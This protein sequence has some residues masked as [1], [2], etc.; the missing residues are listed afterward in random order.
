MLPLIYKKVGDGYVIIAS[1]GGALNHPAWYLNLQGGMPNV[2]FRSLLW[3]LL[4]RPGMQPV[5]SAKHFVIS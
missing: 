2:K 5:M 4:L 1:K 3:V